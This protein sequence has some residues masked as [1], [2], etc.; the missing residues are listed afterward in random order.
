MLRVHGKLNVM[1]RY[2]QELE[3]TKRVHWQHL[4]DLHQWPGRT[5]DCV[6]EL[7]VNGGAVGAITSGIAISLEKR[8]P[9]RSSRSIRAKTNPYGVAH[10]AGGVRAGGGRRMQFDASYSHRG[11]SPVP[12]GPNE[13]GNRSMKGVV[14][15]KPQPTRPLLL[16]PS[17]FLDRRQQRSLQDCNCNRPMSI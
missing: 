4:R 16:I 3:R 12:D 17:P 7:Q 9:D 14:K 1:K 6:C 15:H 10:F 11:F 13:A 2:H 8:N 5:I